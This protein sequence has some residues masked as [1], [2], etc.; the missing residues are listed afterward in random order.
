MIFEYPQV[1]C[2][3]T[4]AVASFALLPTAA[5]VPAVPGGVG[6]HPQRGAGQVGGDGEAAGLGG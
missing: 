6:R 4:A 2:V 1:G 3:V 5:S